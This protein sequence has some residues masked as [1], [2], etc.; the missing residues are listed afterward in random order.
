MKKTMIRNRIDRL[1]EKLADHPADTFWIIQ[2][3]NRRYFSGFKAVDTQL[4]ESSGSLL[5]NKSK[6]LLLTDSR[7]TT[8]AIKEA[9]DFEVVTHRDGLTETLIQHVRSGFASQPLLKIRV[10]AD[11]NEQTDRVAAELAGRVPC[12]VVK[13]VGRVVVL[14]RRPPESDATDHKSQA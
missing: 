14:Y 3:E 4:N 12:E 10:A 11:N 6:A 8:E 1:R 2:P 13:R 9:T 7:Y 5:I